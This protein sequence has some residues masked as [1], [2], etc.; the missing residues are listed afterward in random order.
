MGAR[1]IRVRAACCAVTSVVLGV[2]DARVAPQIP[3]PM[4]TDRVRGL[5]PSP[6]ALELDVLAT[7]SVAGR[8]DGVRWAPEIEWAPTRRLALELELPAGV[9]LAADPSREPCPRDRRAMIDRLHRRALCCS[10]P[11]P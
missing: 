5:G 4:Q 10:M 11:Q 9:P 6:D 8:R 3:E 1:A 7:R 2:A